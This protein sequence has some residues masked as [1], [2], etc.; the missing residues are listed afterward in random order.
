MKDFL[1]ISSLIALVLLW[2]FFFP[3]QYFLAAILII[4][5][6]I[7]YGI[8]QLERKKPEANEL[9][10]TAS[11]S[12]L[13]FVSRILFFAFPQVKPT[14]AI[15]FVS[16]I[17]LGKS[18]GF[19][20]GLLAMFLSNFVFGHGMNTPFQMLGMGLIGFVGGMLQVRFEQQKLKTWHIVL[21]GFL[22]T[23]FVYGVVVD[24][25][26]ALFFLQHGQRAAMLGIYLAGVPFNLVHAVSTA[27]FLAILHPI[28]SKQISRVKL[29]YGLFLEG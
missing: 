1:L 17:T 23:F 10:I 20:I 11:L 8:L 19:I 28:L 15:V 24:T 27:T 26:S 4:C 3:S 12:T 6:V 21:T 5:L 9:A 16:G 29:K 14:A 22:V 13:A 25:G 7:L 18:P 2:F